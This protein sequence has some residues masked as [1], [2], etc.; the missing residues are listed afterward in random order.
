MPSNALKQIDL[1]DNSFSLNKA[2]L[3]VTMSDKAFHDNPDVEPL[4]FKVLKK[5]FCEKTDTRG[6][7]A[8]SE[9][10]QAIVLAFRGTHGN[11]NWLNNI[12]IRRDKFPQVKKFFFK[13]KVHSGFLMG[14]KA[15]REEVTTTMSNLVQKYPTYKFM[16]TGNSLGG[17]IASIAVLD[18]YPLFSRL[19]REITHYVFGSPRPGNRWFAKELNKKYS[20]CYRIVN[21]DDVVPFLPPKIFGY[22]SFNTL[23]HIQKDKSI[24]VN[25]GK[26]TEF[27]SNMDLLF[28]LITGESINDHMS[29]TKIINGIKEN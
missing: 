23:V 2:K 16:I 11:T 24:I 3:L 22:Y 7:V 15:I 5:F 26:L 29:Y 25:P 19:E 20:D 8:I 28:A 12:D 21:D 6:F 13:P 10:L 17:A 1:D 18:L 4:T 27:I 14:Y 9:S